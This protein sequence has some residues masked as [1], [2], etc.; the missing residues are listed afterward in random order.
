MQYTLER[1]AD[2]HREHGGTVPCSRA[3]QPWQG[4]GPPPL[5]LSVHQSLSG[6]SGNQTTNLPVIGRPTLITDVPLKI[7]MLADVCYDGA[8]IP[9]R[10]ED[11]SHED[12]TNW[13]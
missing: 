1:W 6:E 9:D 7:Q 2:I 11:K 5:P 10:N 3:P 8:I 13:I 4:G 12:K